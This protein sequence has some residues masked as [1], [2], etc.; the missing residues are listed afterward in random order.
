MRHRLRILAAVLAAAVTHPAL[1]SA[2]DGPVYEPLLEYRRDT[3]V[4]KAPVLLAQ[5]AEMVSAFAVD[6]DGEL[7]RHSPALNSLVRAGLHFH[8][9]VELA[10]IG[11]GLDFELDALSGLFFGGAD[12]LGDYTPDSSAGQLAVVRRASGRLSAG[13]QVHVIG[14]LMTSHWGMGLLANDG[15]Q[16]WEPGSAR[17][18]DPRGGD[19]VLRGMLAMG[20]FTQGSILVTAGVDRVVEDD[21]LLEGDEANQAV[22][23]AT[24]GHLQPT[25]AGFYVVRRSQETA[26]GEDINIWAFNAAGAHRVTLG[27]RAALSLEAEAAFITGTTTLSPTPQ[28]PVS[29]VRQFSGAA[30]AGLD[31]GKA[32]AVLDFLYASGDHDFS[33]GRQSAFRVDSNYASGLLLHR[34]V[35]AAQTS[36]AT[37]TAADPDLAAYPPPDLDRFPSQGL[38]TNTLSFFPRGWWR[39]VD[40]LELY[41]GPLVAF[42]PARQA[43]PYHTHLAGGAPRNAFGAEASR[44]LGTELALGVRYRRLMAGTELTAGLEGATLLPGPAFD[45][46]TG[47]ESMGSVHG[48]RAMVEY[49]F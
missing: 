29:D 26:L 27:E 47:D 38:I 45:L 19:R 32:G 13:R 46:A 44:Y 25:R 15:G 2:E 30:R 23:S 6:A 4:L 7:Y 9:G 43:D 14:G 1:L 24:F 18:A 34:Y 49:R 10:P 33:D 31:L 20:P 37:V 48:G 28:H 3:L 39:P 41:G 5:R 35:V 22:L 8:S 40:G 16:T 11:V 36:R 12:P 17:F 21:A 42:A